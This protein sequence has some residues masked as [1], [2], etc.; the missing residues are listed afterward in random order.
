MK[1]ASGKTGTRL[2]TLTCSAIV[3][4]VMLATCANAAT[5]AAR[6]VTSNVISISGDR[7]TLAN[8]KMQI[9]G[10]HVS[11]RKSGLVNNFSPD[12]TPLAPAPALES[13]GI[14][15]TP[16]LLTVPGPRLLSVGF[17][18]GQRLSAGD[19]S[20]SITRPVRRLPGR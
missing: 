8:V 7:R 14:L 18:Q 15:T 19:G 6:E 10:V 20:S 4:C 13:S 1:N 2:W 12:L 9:L 16:N 5:Q 3:G 17:V 11:P